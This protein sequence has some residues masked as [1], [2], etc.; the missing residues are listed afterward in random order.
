AADPRHAPAWS[1]IGFLLA[2][3]GE[4]EEAIAAFERVLALE[5]QDARSHFNVAYLLQR[6]GRH[7]AAIA[8]FERTLALDPGIDRA[9]KGLDA[10][11]AALEK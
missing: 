7:E 5:P 8:R 10:S 6:L 2:A 1:G 11:R 9:R 4:C 3:R